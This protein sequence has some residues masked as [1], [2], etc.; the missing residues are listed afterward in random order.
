MPRARPEPSPA[1]KERH[2]MLKRAGATVSAYDAFLKP[3][4]RKTAVQQLISN[5]LHYG[6]R[7]R[8]EAFARLVYFDGSPHVAFRQGAAQTALDNKEGKKMY[9]CPL[10]KQLVPELSMAHEYHKLVDIVEDV[11]N[12]NPLETRLDELKELSIKRH[13]ALGVSFQMVCN[14]GCNN[15]L[16][17]K[18]YSDEV[19]AAV[20]GRDPP[21]SSV[22][23]ITE[24]LVPPS[25]R[26]AKR[27][28]PAQRE[29]PAALSVRPIDGG[30]A[31]P[32]L[33]KID[34]PLEHCS[35]VALPGGG[36]GL[37]IG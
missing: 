18:S 24:Y 17:N 7:A 21:A 22:R 3:A 9:L 2:D 34:A 27:P 37:V 33:Y 23:P 16:E 32:R 12:N 14:R 13:Y 35:L 25:E 31:F 19:S 5:Q 29:A 10:C 20:D 6:N 4:A 30:N 26:P 15:A 11:V 36:T 28:A 1:D 8:K